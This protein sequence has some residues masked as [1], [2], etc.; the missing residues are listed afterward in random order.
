MDI[1][2][3]NID[4][5]GQ[6]QAMVNESGNYIGF[7]AAS[8]LTSWLD[9]PLPALDGIRPADLLDTIEGQTLVSTILA[10]MQSGAYA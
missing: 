3:T 2:E 6:V 9:A 4:L 10:Q 8:W 1:Q 5:F 7:D